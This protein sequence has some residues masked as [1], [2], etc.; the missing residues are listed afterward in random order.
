MPLKKKIL[1]F[2]THVFLCVTCFAQTYTIDSLKKVLPAL[3][4]KARIDCLNELGFE[5]SNSYW[6]NSKY[7]QTDTALFYTQQAQN[8]SQQLNYLAGMGK[9]LHNRAMINEEHGDLVAAENYMRKALG[10]FATENME[11]EY[12]RSHVLLGWILH[13]RGR[14]GQSIQ[15]YKNEL[16]YYEAS[17][18]AVGLAS[19]Y[20]NLARAYEWQG[21]SENAFTWFQK[22]FIL[23]KKPGSTPDKRINASLIASVYL[24]A[25]DSANAANY[26]KQTA[27]FSI[28]PH[29]SLNADYLNM[30]MAYS[31][32][33]KYDTAMIKIRT[34]INKLK[35]TNSDS[36]LRKM[37]LMSSYIALTDLFLTQKKFD[38]V[39]TY[40]RQAIMFFKKG[41]FKTALLPLLKTLATAY[42]EKA[43]YSRALYYSNQLVEMAQHSGARRF[44]RDGYKLLWQIYSARNNLKFADDFHLKYLVLN[45]S[46]E[47]DKY[48]SQTAA[49]QV[50]NERNIHDLKFENQLILNE[51]RNKAKIQSINNEKKAQLKVFIAAL[52][53]IS[54]IAVLILRNYWLKR[55][56]DQL[57]LMM[58]EANLLLEKQK[59]EQDIVR[60][61]QQ[62]KDLKMQALRAQMNPHFIF[63]CLSSINR[64]I[65]IN[66][67]DE[68]SDYLTKFSRLIRMALQSSEKSLINLENELESL[69]LYLDLERLRFKNSFNYSIR[70]INEIELST[71]CIPPMLMQPFVENAIWHGLMHKQGTGYLDIT[72]STEEKI[73]TCIITD[74]GIGRNKA[75]IIKSKSAEKNKS[76]GVKITSERLELLSR[77]KDEE[78]AFKIEDLTDNEGNALGTKVVLKMKYKSFMDTY[79]YQKQ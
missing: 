47:M 43:Q 7:Q 32:Q 28:T 31:F 20:R 62:K 58:M 5:F 53:L 75:A 73:L 39:I 6:S 10:I 17:K 23:N 27:L 61:Q 35:S 19:L 14:F 77:N 66:K 24:A 26:F 70:F 1:I 21:N 52:S 59:K 30:A 56:R 60:L 64:Y 41:D 34:G 65:L 72:F 12:H 18:N 46:L 22:D 50:I 15:I 8:E 38:S 69:R 54:L 63:N 40:G 67:T 57:Q 33:K 2:V 11:A 9:A 78:A 74:D 79:E 48:I 68:A 25:G 51:A 16:P 13:N 4:G 37:A 49:W 36:L 71:V 44:E 55:K 42:K 45:D 76:L 29:A 3:K